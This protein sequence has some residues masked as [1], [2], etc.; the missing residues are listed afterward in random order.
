[1]ALIN[2][3][4]H[5]KANLSEVA[6]LRNGGIRIQSRGG[7]AAAPYVIVAPAAAARR[8]HVGT[9]ALRRRQSSSNARNAFLSSEDP[10]L[11]EC[12]GV[13]ACT[14]TLRCSVV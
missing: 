1:M 6:Q 9:G 8:G 12:F 11:K 3:I 7:P 4:R 5:A 13:L 2:R 14:C 10:S